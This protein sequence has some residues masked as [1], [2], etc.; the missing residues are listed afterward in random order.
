MSKLHD[1]IKELEP[2]MMAI[3]VSLAKEIEAHKDSKLALHDITK[4]KAK[5]ARI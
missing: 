1:H 2:K 5:L 4:E 3:D